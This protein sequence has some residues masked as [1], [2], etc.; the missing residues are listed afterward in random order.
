MV[1]IIFAAALSLAIG[2]GLPLWQSSPA[3]AEDIWHLACSPESGLR[4]ELDSGSNS[5]AENV[6]KALFP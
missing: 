4:F 3:S 6:E 5:G 2:A 1:R